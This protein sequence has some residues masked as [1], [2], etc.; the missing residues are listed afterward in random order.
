M[1]PLDQTYKYRMCFVGWTA[2]TPLLF[3]TWGAIECTSKLVS[4]GNFSYGIHHGY[5][6]RLKRSIKTILKK[7]TYSSKYNSYMLSFITILS[8]NTPLAILPF[9][10]YLLPLLCLYYAAAVL[11]IT[12]KKWLPDPFLYRIFVICNLILTSGCV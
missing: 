8:K 12:S 7:N 2:K 11:L 4:P 10:Y 1:L 5:K 6:K 9:K 3:Y